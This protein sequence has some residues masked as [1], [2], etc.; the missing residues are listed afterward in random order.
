MI[1]KNKYFLLITLL[2]TLG[3]Q[4]SSLS[5]FSDTESTISQYTQQIK[6]FE[7]K[8]SEI[9]VDYSRSGLSSEETSVIPMIDSDGLN[10]D[11]QFLK[12][13]TLSPRLPKEVH[14]Y[15]QLVI[16]ERFQYAERGHETD[17]FTFPGGYLDTYRKGKCDEF[18]LNALQHLYGSKNIFNLGYVAVWEKSLYLSPFKNRRGHAFVT[19]QNK[20]GSWKGI[21]N[22]HDIGFS[23][24]SL[25]GLIKQSLLPFGFN[26][27]LTFAFYIPI[28]DIPYEAIFF[29]KREDFNL[30][31]RKLELGRRVL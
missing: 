8:N 20:D 17:C 25:D 7:I 10:Y 24:G 9:K 19:Y 15:L 12:S 21:S 29:D 16:E 6:D 23:S 31:L 27:I 26:P 3:C 11:N 1:S 4:K 28:N 13:S 14:D 5:I 2:Y 18:A 30:Q 22:G